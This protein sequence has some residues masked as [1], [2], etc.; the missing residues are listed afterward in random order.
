MLAH[1]HGV[2]PGRFGLDGHP[3]QRAEIARRDERV[4][5]AQD[6]DEAGPDGPASPSGHHALVRRSASASLAGSRPLT[7]NITTNPMTPQTTADQGARMVGLGT[8]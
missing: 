8:L 3:N 5:L 4:V 6:E 7:A 1:H 2:E